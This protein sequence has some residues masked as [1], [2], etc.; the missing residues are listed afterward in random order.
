[1]QAHWIYKLHEQSATEVLAFLC[2]SNFIFENHVFLISVVL[3]TGSVNFPCIF[4]FAV[5]NKIIFQIAN[6]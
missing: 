2:S 1:M 6:F 5:K 3:Y 4:K